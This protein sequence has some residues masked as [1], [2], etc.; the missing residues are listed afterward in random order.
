MGLD[1]RGVINVFVELPISVIDLVYSIE[2]IT[3]LGSQVLRE[4][5]VVDREG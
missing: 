2:L 4:V 1:A 5:I 3:D